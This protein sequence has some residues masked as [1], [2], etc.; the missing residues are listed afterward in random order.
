MGWKQIWGVWVTEERSEGLLQWARET[1]VGMDSG[2]PCIFLSPGL[3]F[4]SPTSQ[5]ALQF[6]T[7]AVSKW[8]RMEEEIKVRN[9]C[10]WIPSIIAWPPILGLDRCLKLECFPGSS[11]GCQPSPPTA[12]STCISLWLDYSLSVD[13]SLTGAAFYVLTL[14]QEVQLDRT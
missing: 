2:R 4:P 11:R 6:P 8:G 7:L 14:S 1:M 10:I 3:P 12:I 13:P 9:N 5:L